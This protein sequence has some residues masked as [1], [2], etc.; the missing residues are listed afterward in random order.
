MSDEPEAGVN[1]DSDP[2]QFESVN[3]GVSSIRKGKHAWQWIW[4]QGQMTERQRCGTCMQERV[5][6]R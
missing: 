1:A 6:T 4:E 5:P 3:D 2:C